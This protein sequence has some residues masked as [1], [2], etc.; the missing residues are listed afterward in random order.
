M[1]REKMSDIVSFPLF[2]LTLAINLKKKL[3]LKVIQILEYF[4]IKNDMMSGLN[5]SHGKISDCHFKRFL[6]RLFKI[7]CNILPLLCVKT[8]FSLKTKKLKC[9]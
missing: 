6:L 4:L 3:I 7:I 5:M 9:A 8:P 2:G 1:T